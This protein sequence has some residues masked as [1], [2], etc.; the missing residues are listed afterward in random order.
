MSKKETKEKKAKKEKRRF[1]DRRDGKLIRDLDGMHLIMP[2]MYPGRCANEAFINVMVDLTEAKK[3]L[4]EKNSQNPAY[5]YSFFHLLLTAL[6][7][8]LTLRPKMNRFIANKNMY[9]RNEVSL[10]FTIKQALTDDGEEGLAFVHTTEESTLETIRE[11][12]R[13]Q[14]ENCK[15]GGVDP[16][17]QTLNFFTK[18]PRFFTR[19]F[20]RFARWLD[21]HGKMPKSM[22]ETDPYYSSCVISNLGSVRVGSC[23]HHLTEWGT[24]SFFVTMGEVKK[25]PVFQNDG[26]FEMRESIDLGLTIDERIADGYYYGKTIRMLKKLLENPWVL[27]ETLSTPVTFSPKKAVKAEKTESEQEVAAAKA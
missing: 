14:I 3:Y 27:E 25:R 2:M 24:T 1:G 19:V 6:A 15:Q 4:Y 8:C 18:V 17:S 5:R 10:A 7:R 21:R 13:A 23:Y 16:S 12:M 26:T 9:Q 20:V 22:I 11:D